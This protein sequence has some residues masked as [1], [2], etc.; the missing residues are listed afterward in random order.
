M[1]TVGTKER[2]TPMSWVL[3]VAII[4]GLIAVT[5]FSCDGKEKRTA[6]IAQATTPEQLADRLEKLV[7]N[8]GDHPAALLLKPVAGT[9]VTVKP[10]DA[11]SKKLSLVV[12]RNNSA[13]VS[14]DDLAKL[15]EGALAAAEPWDTIA[16]ETSHADTDRFGQP[17]TTVTAR[18]W[19]R[20]VLQ[21]V[22]WATFPSYKLLALAD[23]VETRHLPAIGPSSRPAE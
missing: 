17:Q 15:I 14:L 12:R 13:A 1:T 18:T 22:K 3:L 7:N 4:V 16:V 5:R 6:M 20:T 8:G 10:Y 2:M 23:K 19:Q 9:T 11:A 21:K